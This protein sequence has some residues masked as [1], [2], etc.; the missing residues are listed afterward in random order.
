MKKYILYLSVVF[1]GC[2]DIPAAYAQTP[3]SL[4]PGDRMPDIMLRNIAN[5]ATDSVSMDAL[6]GKLV[7]FDFWSVTCAS[8]IA[9]IPSMEALQ[10]EFGDHIQIFLVTSDVSEIVH[11]LADRND[12]IR[13]TSL[14]SIVGDTMLTRL[15]SFRTVPTHVWIDEKGYVSQLT[16]GF[17]T[18]RSTVSRY[19]A[20]E[21]IQL[22][23]KNEYRD[24]DLMSPLVTE[25]NGRQTKHLMYYSG[26]FGK[27]DDDGSIEDVIRDKTTG[28]TVGYRLVNRSLL[29]LYS[30]AYSSKTIPRSDNARFIIESGHPALQTK[31]NYSDPAYMRWE[32]EYSYSYESRMPL[33]TA[34]RLKE[35]MREDLFRWF[36]LDVRT[37]KRRVR[38]LVLT[39]A[40]TTILNQPRSAWKERKAATGV[41]T[42]IYR[43]PDVDQFVNTLR[44]QLRFIGMPV[45]HDIKY[46]GRISVRLNYERFD[47]RGA[48]EKAL[49]EMGFTLKEEERDLDMVIIAD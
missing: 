31:P 40:D 38:C 6:S 41:T 9:A 27:I 28:K 36:G 11:K 17:N 44:G 37:E 34:S 26:V 2:W 45:V 29:D 5:Y 47:D 20:G 12:I 1:V 14:P 46:T 8:C 3:R 49:A 16:S 23:V 21:E 33:G 35:F 13:N 32:E 25:G 10:R 42:L 7:I 43:L 39:V 4:V 30:Y 48:I 15:F 22:T 19:L 18:T 24:F